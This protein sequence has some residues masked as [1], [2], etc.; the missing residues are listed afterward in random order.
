MSITIFGSIGS[1]ASRC[2]W[3]AEELGLRY[4]W[5]PISTLDGSN[6]RPEYLAINPSGKIPALADGDVVMTESMAINQYLAE[7]YGRGSLWPNERQL[8]ARVLQWTFWSAT[9]IEPFITE[10]FPQFV[11]K[12]VA[13]RDAA[14]TE[15]LVAA[16]LKKL[17]ELEAALAGRDFVLERFTLADVNLAVQTF[18]FVDRFHLDLGRLP[19]LRD[20]T[21]RCRARPARQRVESM[22]AAAAAP[23]P[24]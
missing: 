2:I 3:V 18:T 8:R 17:A 19:N 6:R 13:E 11:T 7:E 9:E 14:L 10:L 20:W 15:R 4:E 23:R 22:V 12:P 16:L 5:K 1:R 21:D 24:G